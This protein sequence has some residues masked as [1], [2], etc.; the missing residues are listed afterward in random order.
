[1]NLYQAMVA[2]R[3]GAHMGRIKT[4]AEAKYQDWTGRLSAARKEAKGPNPDNDPAVAAILAEQPGHGP[5][6]EAVML[7]ALRS[8]ELRASV[9]DGVDVRPISP[10]AWR[11]RRLGPGVLGTVLDGHGKVVLDGGNVTFDRQK[12]E[13]F[14]KG[15]VMAQAESRKPKLPTKM[16]KEFLQE[17]SVAT[18]STPAKRKA[19]AEAREQFPEYQ[20]TRSIIEPAHKSLF[21]NLPP[22]KRV[23]KGNVPG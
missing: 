12:V 19:E 17:L 4:E 10:E 20:V 16:A 15:E 5:A 8:G 23:P 21:G 14:A 7:A 11:V 18:G 1:M 6:P 22:G 9:L 2:I 13:A 3:D